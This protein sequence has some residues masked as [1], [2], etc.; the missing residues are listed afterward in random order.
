MRMIN[1]GLNNSNFIDSIRESD[2]SSS[3]SSVMNVED[4]NIKN[5]FEGEEKKEEGHPSSRNHLDLT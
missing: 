4:S 5:S 1:Q 2:I 3:N